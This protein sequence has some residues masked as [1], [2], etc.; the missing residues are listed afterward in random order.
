MRKP[1]KRVRVIFP[2]ERLT[3]NVIPPE[4]NL[5]EIDYATVPKKGLIVTD[6]KEFSLEISEFT[7]MR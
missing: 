5:D 6:G 7:V 3:I 1:E 2:G 4:V